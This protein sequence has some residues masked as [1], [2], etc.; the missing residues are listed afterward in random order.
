MEDG[1]LWEIRGIGKMGVSGEL[2]SFVRACPVRQTLIPD[3][4][5]WG[6]VCVNALCK[7]W[8]AMPMCRKGYDPD[9]QSQP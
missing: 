6:A 3:K 1:D 9:F 8:H 7:L 2:G 4:D 5:A